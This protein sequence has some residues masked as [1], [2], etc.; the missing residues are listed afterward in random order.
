VER[1]HRTFSPALGG[2]DVVDALR[3]AAL[4][5]GFGV[6]WVVT[7]PHKAVWKLVL[8]SVLA[9]MLLSGLIELIQILSP[10]RMSSVL[11]IVTDTLGTLAGA[12]VVALLI[13]GVSRSRGRAAWLR[14]PTWLL[15]GAY[16]GAVL[17]EATSPLFRQ[18]PITAHGLNPF[19]RL[20][21]AL[22]QAHVSL[23]SSNVAIDLVLDAFLFAP[24]GA[25]WVVALREMGVAKSKCIW[26]IGVAAALAFIGSEVLH[27]IFGTEI[28][29]LAPVV[30]TVGVTGGALLAMALGSKARTGDS[31]DRTLRDVWI[32]YG[33]LLVLWSTRPFL[34]DIDLN[35]MSEQLTRTHLIPMLSLATRRDLY[36]VMHVIRQTLLF[37]PA[38]ALLAV[39]PFAERGWM[40]HLLPVFHAAVLLEL[41]HLVIVGRYFDTTNIILACAGAGLGWIVVRTAGIGVRG[42]VRV[43]VRK[44]VSSARVDGMRHA[45]RSSW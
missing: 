6:V 5:A 27:G 10:Y 7:A 8:E 9:A 36:S 13:E 32:F 37:M 41:T 29:P 4:F 18:D 25:L 44:P 34:P 21:D 31:R 17:A 26:I 16:T 11:D 3:N 23:A 22:N 43:R 14:V 40:A 15:A 2:S 45:N 42:K 1:L 12:A 28:V 38:G 24:A 19:G 33:M 20:E 35:A 39:W 30:H